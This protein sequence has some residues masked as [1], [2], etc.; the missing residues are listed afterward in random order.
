[1]PA[2]IHISAVMPQLFPVLI[3][4]IKWLGA[5]ERDTQV[6]NDGP[7]TCKEQST[8]GTLSLQETWPKGKRN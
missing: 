1:M 5:Q 3:E 8:S 7:T 4:F 2:R 6:Q